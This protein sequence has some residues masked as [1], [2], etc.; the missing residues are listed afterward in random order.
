M[1]HFNPDQT[2]LLVWGVTVHV[3]ADWFLQNHWMATNK[4]SLKHPAAYVHSGVHGLLSLIVFPW[5]ACVVL[6]V[7]HLLIDLRVPLA[8]WG[9]LVGQS[10]AEQI[11]PAYIPFAFLRD[12]A[13]HWLVIALVA[14]G[15]GR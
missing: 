5:Q 1:T 10:T 2:A 7:A 14:W 6:F 15:C 9:K 8:W 13:A 3:V 12:Q 4:T 11:G